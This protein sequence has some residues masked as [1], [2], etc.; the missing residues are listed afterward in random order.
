MRSARSSQL[1]NVRRVN[2]RL[3]LEHQKRH[4]SASR[5]TSTPALAGSKASEVSQSA[6]VSVFCFLLMLVSTLS[7]L[8]SCGLVWTVVDSQVYLAIQVSVDSLATLVSLEFLDTLV[9]QVILE[10]PVIVAIQV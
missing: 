5:G 4:L 1:T 6:S 8:D 2:F 9:S 3:L 7:T 10:P